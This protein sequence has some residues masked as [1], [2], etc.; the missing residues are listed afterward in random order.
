MKIFV[1][2]L[3][4]LVYLIKIEAAS[5]L[6]APIFEDEDI[7]SQYTSKNCSVIVEIKITASGGGSPDIISEEEI[8]SDQIPNTLNAFYEIFPNLREKINAVYARK[9]DYYLMIYETLCEPGLKKKSKILLEL[10]PMK[11]SRSLLK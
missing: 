1:I 10:M 8:R 5:K 4:F 11:S 3:A 9:D 2:I 6:E 7:L